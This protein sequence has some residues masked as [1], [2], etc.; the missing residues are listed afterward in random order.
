MLSLKTKV[1]SWFAGTVPELQSGVVRIEAECNAAAT[2]LAEA[3][4]A[5]GRALLVETGGAK[6]I[7]LVRSARDAVD[8]A[9][10]KLEAA[11]ALLKAAQAAQA[12]RNQQVKAVEAVAEREAV[13]KEC[14]TLAELSLK[15]GN[16]VREVYETRLELA[17]RAEALNRR[18]QMSDFYLSHLSYVALGQGVDLEFRRLDARHFGND[19][20]MHDRKPLHEH[21]SEIFNHVGGRANG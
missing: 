12:E 7:A 18:T 9:T 17:T 5:H 8:A 6:E 16:A 19:S 15:L 1:E 2:A 4:A 14:Q 10:S 20:A 3:R 13:E 11:T 21:L